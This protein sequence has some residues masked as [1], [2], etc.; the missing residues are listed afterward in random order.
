MKAAT[1]IS[2]MPPAASICYNMLVELFAARWI[3]MMIDDADK[4]T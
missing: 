3:N 1:L 2:Q 4:V